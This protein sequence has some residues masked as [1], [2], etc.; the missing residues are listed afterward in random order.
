MFVYSL[1]QLYAEAPAYYRD[2]NIQKH[3]KNKETTTTTKNYK[4]F[5][6]GHFVNDNI[7]NA[8]MKIR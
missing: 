6:A 4:K 1:F 8:G 7:S 5:V 2:I 3:Y